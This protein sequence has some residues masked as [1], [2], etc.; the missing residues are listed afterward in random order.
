[1]EDKIAQEK[2]ERRIAKIE[3]QLQPLYK[4]RNAI[5]DKLYFMEQTKLIGTHWMFK[6]NN[7]GG[8]RSPK[9]DVYYEIIGITS[10]GSLIYNSYELI[11]P[12]D[13]FGHTRISIHRD[14]HCG[15]WASMYTKIT[16]QEFNKGKNAVLKALEIETNETNKV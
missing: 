7:Y 4:K 3:K 5:R 9:W 12:S 6:D 2:Y 11:P 1:V 14:I 15:S 10:T 8:G 16:E 13:D